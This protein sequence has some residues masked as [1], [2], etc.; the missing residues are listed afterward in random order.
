MPD[1]EKMYFKLAAKMADAIET[2]DK[3]SHDLKATQIE[4]EEMY[5]ASGDEDEKDRA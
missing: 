1:F 4:S 5:I 3:V 2:L